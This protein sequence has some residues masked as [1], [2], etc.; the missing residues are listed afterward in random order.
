VRCCR[1]RSRRAIPWQV[2]TATRF[3]PLDMTSPRFATCSVKR[4][5]PSLSL[6][7]CLA[8]LGSR[9]VILSVMNVEAD[10]MTTL[11]QRSGRARLPH[12]FGLQKQIRAH[13]RC[14]SCAQRSQQQEALRIHVWPAARGAPILLASSS[15]RP[16]R[17]AAGVRG[18]PGWLAR[19]GIRRRRWCVCNAVAAAC[20][21]VRWMLVCRKGLVVLGR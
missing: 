19:G 2:S 20:A 8:V 6:C 10:V 16:L 21:L 13:L 5:S 7:C 12:R 9:L 11:L 14:G 18:L 4:M 3:R 15:R 1:A 17:S